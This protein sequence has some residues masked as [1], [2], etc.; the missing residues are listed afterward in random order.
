M[1]FVEDLSVFFADFGVPAVVGV[2]TAITVIFDKAY[3]A[4]LNGRLEGE[5]PECLGRTEDIGD[6]QEGDPIT[7][8]GIPYTVV[9]APQSDG[10]GLTILQLRA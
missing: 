2:D 7:I 10:T 3:I 4:Q 8:D 9:G 5:N 6:M 1:A